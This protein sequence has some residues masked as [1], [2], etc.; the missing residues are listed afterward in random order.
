MQ[1]QTANS[2][3]NSIIDLFSK[4]RHEYYYGCQSQQQIYFHHIELLSSFLS[5]INDLQPLDLKLIQNVFIFYLMNNPN[6]PN[7]AIQKT[8]V[9]SEL[10]KLTDYASVIDAYSDD[11]SLWN[12]FY[13]DLAN[14][15]EEKIS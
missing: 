1:N 13:N 5:R 8:K 7:E 9:L 12:E 2:E 14:G 6:N 11:L 15:L 10:E 3:T 4:I